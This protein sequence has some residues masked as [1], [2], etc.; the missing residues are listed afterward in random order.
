MLKREHINKITKSSFG[1]KFTDRHIAYTNAKRM[2]VNN[3]MMKNHSNK[4]RNM[5]KIHKL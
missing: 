2:Q 1:N 3:E 5:I 4:H